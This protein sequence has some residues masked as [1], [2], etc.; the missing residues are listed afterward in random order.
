[1]SERY[2]S[3]AKKRKLK[4]DREASNEKAVVD[5]DEKHGGNGKADYREGT[6]VNENEVDNEQGLQSVSEFETD[7]SCWTF[8][9]LEMKRYWAVHGPK[10]CQNR[11]VSFF[12]S[13]RQNKVNVNKMKTSCFSASLL[14]RKL[15]NAEEID[16][17]WLLYSPSSGKVFCF[18]CKLFGGSSTT[19]LA[20]SGFDY[21][22]H[23][24]SISQHE[25]SDAHFENVK[26]CTAFANGEGWLIE[27]QHIKLLQQEEEHGKGVIIRVIEAVRFLA[28]RGLAFR[29]DSHVIGHPKNGNFL[30]II[31]LLSK[32]DPF[33]ADHLARYVGNAAA[34]C[35]LQAVSFFSTVQEVYTFLAAST[36]RWNTM[37]SKLSKRELVVKKICDTRWSARHDAIR[38]LVLAPRSMK[39][40]LDEIALDEDQTLSTRNDATSLS[41][42]L[43]SF[44]FE[45]MAV[46][47][48]DL[49]KR[50]HISNLS[51]QTVSLTMPSAIDLLNSLELFISGMRNREE[52][53]RYLDKAKTF[54]DSTEQQFKDE[55]KRKKKRLRLADESAKKEV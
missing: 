12:K 15:S 9:S 22:K 51:L 41:E 47:W 53:Q 34:Q 32:F 42:K 43:E 6:S 25:R 40:T 18:Y 2:P 29:G 14:K 16:R 45:L 46:F 17:D 33:L 23:P 52:Y 49:L 3:G 39:E 19:A 11:D 5:P 35:C 1:M 54:L 20:S 26:L 30:G 36:H 8:I 10:Q 24:E 37:Q 31:E 55:M 48:N 44:E 21:W 50:I 13:S 27:S 38:A 7:P 4:K 28:E